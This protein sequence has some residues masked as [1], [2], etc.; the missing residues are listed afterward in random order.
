MRRL[1][2]FVRS[3]ERGVA[4]MLVLWVIVVLG[5][6]AAGVAAWAHQSL[7]VARTT[8]T[9]A[10]ARSAAESGVIAA[11][12][13]LEELYAESGTPEARAGAFARFDEEVTRAGQ[14]AFGEARYQIAVVDLGSRI[15]LN[16]AGAPILVP[17]FRQV[18][19]EREA[20]R[21]VAA[22]E[23]WKDRDRRPRPGGAEAPQYA[24][25]GSPFTPPNAPMLRLDE[26]TRVRG[27][28]DSIAD[29]L[30]PYVTVLGSGRVNLNTAPRPVLAA[31]PELGPSGADAVIAARGGGRLLASA[32]DVRA[33]FADRGLTTVLSMRSRTT[34]ADRVLVISRG[35][36]DGSSL[37]HEVQ[38]VLQLR[39][40][41]A[42]APPE[43]RVVHWTERDL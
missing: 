34:I 36:Q 32:E 29:L 3:D 24:A 26:L 33:L 25:A 40:S 11:K 31:L 14:R 4:L 12:A 8:R 21:L 20:L 42:D 7:D 1:S 23:D 9:R 18:V 27:F 13:R 5:G 41:T 39:M 17:L 10:V 16:Q 37:T 38:A 22:L 19:G 2:T 15:D 30:A 43:W 28:T 6:I 35:W